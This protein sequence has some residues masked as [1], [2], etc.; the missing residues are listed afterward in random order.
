MRRDEL[1]CLEISLKREDD[2][3]TKE[4]AQQLNI[5][6]VLSLSGCSLFGQAGTK[7]KDVILEHVTQV[8][9]GHI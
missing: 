2:R 6:V 4:P 1:S 3:G 8:A 7:T 9:L 5:E